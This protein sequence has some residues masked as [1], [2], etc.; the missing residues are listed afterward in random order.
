MGEYVGVYQAGKTHAPEGPIR[1][2]HH[3]HAVR[4]RNIWLVELPEETGEG[5]DPA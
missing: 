5:K 4:Y 2:Q 3:R 1:L